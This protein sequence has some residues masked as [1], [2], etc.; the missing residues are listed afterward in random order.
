VDAANDYSVAGK[1][2]DRGACRVLFK[3]EIKMGQAKGGV[4][5]LEPCAMIALGT[6]PRGDG[7]AIAIA[8]RTREGEVQSA[9]KAGRRRR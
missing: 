5:G 3:G 9:A 6:A 4:A 2:A 8:M 1:L 7:F